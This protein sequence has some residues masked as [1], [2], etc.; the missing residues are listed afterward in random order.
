M[1]PTDLIFLYFC[2]CAL[3]WGAHWMKVW[4]RNDEIKQ[5]EEELFYL[6][7]ENWVLYGKP[8]PEP[9]GIMRYSNSNPT[10]RI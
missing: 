6:V 9:T 8:G 10:D 1:T 2:A 5:L 4:E 7:L 3:S